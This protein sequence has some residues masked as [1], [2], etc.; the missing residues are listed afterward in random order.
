MKTNKYFNPRRFYRLT[1]AD[2]RLNQ[3]RYL[4]SLA[5]AAIV[6]YLIILYFMWDTYN[7][8]REFSHHNYFGGFMLCLMILGG[9]VGSAFPDLSDK[10]GTNNYLLFPASTLEKVLSQF[11][12]YFVC[13]IFFF[14]LI[15]WIDTYLAGWT[16][17]L[18]ESVRLGE[19]KIESFRF[20]SLYSHLDDYRFLFLTAMCVISL[21]TFLF[22]CRLFFRRYAFIKSLVVLVA[23]G[24]LM[25]CC[26]VLFS[27]LF[28]PATKGFTIA[29]L[30]V[31]KVYGEINNFE[32]LSMAIAYLSWIFMLP[33]AYFK[34]KEKQG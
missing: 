3:K 12:I 32:L 6:F 19:C 27:H 4:F 5:G 23:L 16:M 25:F 8:W 1:V 28:Y 33:L 34:L 9:F 10:K 30:Q 22:A 11:L 17:H 18:K 20:S 26:M 24:G 31:Y 21:G 14:L 7:V 15:F 29:T 13:G 2:L